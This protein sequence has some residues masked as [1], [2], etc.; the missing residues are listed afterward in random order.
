MTAQT[1]RVPRF[2]RET[3]AASGTIERIFM[4][5]YASGNPRDSAHATGLLPRSSDARWILFHDRMHPG[6]DQSVLTH[7]PEQTVPPT[8]IWKLA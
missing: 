5:A 4:K 6:G 3:V 2:E 8:T 7:R 1:P